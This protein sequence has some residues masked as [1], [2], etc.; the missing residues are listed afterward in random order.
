MNAEV[1]YPKETFPMKW[2]SQDRRRDASV[3]KFF[4]FLDPDLSA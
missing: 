3:W 2:G 4:E 1:P